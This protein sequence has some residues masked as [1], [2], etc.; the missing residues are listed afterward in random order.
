MSRVGEL[1]KT[2][3]LS[4]QAVPKQCETI[5]QEINTVEHAQGHNSGIS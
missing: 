4:A 3:D 5:I 2:S 1:G